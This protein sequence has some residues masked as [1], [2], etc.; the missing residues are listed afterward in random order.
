V[1][2]IAVILTLLVAP[3]FV[4][5]VFYLNVVA[6][7]RIRILPNQLCGGK[8]RALIS[9]GKPELAIQALAFAGSTSSQA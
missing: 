6:S 4:A 1:I 8:R 9:S 5:R 3:Y 7:A 2:N